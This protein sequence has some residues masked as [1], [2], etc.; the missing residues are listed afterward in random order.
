MIAGTAHGFGRSDATEA[1]QR[2]AGRQRSYIRTRRHH[3][4]RTVAVVTEGQ[5]ASLRSYITQIEVHVLRQL[6]LHGQIP[7]LGVGVAQ[8]GIESAGAKQ[9][10]AGLALRA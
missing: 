3:L 9:T 2:P 7:L 5:I 8:V 1:L 10:Y 4:N 6:L